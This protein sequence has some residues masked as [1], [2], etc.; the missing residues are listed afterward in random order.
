MPSNSRKHKTARFYCRF[1]GCT[2]FMH[3]PNGLTQHKRA[4]R[5]NPAN[6]RAPTPTSP[7]PPPASSPH[8]ASVR[9]GF[10]PPRTPSPQPQQDR[11]IPPSPSHSSPRRHAWGEKTRPH[12]GVTYHEYLSGTYRVSSRCIHLPECI[13]RRPLRR[14]WLRHPPQP[15]AATP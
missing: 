1:D 13:N 7:S 2:R 15:T 11:I 14:K 5:F 10:T 8:P 3:N 6:I 4:C 12:V 9:N